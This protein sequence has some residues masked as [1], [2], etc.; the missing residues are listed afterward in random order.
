MNFEFYQFKLVVNK[1]TNEYEKV[2]EWP[3]YTLSID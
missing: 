1:K 3:F 2:E